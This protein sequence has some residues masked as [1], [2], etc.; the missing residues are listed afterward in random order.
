MRRI[1]VNPHRN[2][3]EIR[4]YSQVVDSLIQYTVDF[5]LAVSDRSDVSSV[6]S[7]TWE[8]VGST[9]LTFTDSAVASD[10]ATVL[11]SATNCG[12][13]LAKLT[14][15]YDTGDIEVQYIKVDIHDPEY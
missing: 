11:I 9:L 13:G 1:L 2:N 5:S 3:S 15:T 10:V 12:R 4:K 14:A 8:S 6:S 7:V